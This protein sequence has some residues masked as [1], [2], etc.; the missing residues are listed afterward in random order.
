MTSP[1]AARPDATADDTEYSLSIEEAADRYA[2]AGHPRTPR[3]IQRY[4][5]RGDLDCRKIETTFGS[6]YLIAAYSVARHIAQIEEVT[7][8]TGRAETRPVAEPVAASFGSATANQPATGAD[9]PTQKPIADA[10]PSSLAANS[11]PYELP[12][13]PRPD[14]TVSRYVEQLE[15]D[16]DFLRDQVVVKDGQIRELTERAK[17]TNH[18]IGGLQRMLAPLL[19][20]GRGHDRYDGA[21]GDNSPVRDV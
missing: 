10:L 2:H 17:E 6:R 3:S 19:G 12:D 13:L 21:P 9:R 20:S 18:L 14:A 11:L 5:A 1:D 16:N 15:R 7:Q 4:C 8:A